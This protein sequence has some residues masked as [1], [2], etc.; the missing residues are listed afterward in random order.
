[1]KLAGQFFKASAN[2]ST[3]CNEELLSMAHPKKTP[4]YMR[5][6]KTE[7]RKKE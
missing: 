5:N 6:E 3:F 4:I 1:M 2:W 7:E